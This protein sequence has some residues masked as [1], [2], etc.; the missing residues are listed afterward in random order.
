MRMT[1]LQEWLVLLVVTLP[2]SAVSAGTLD[3]TVMLGGVIMNQDGDRTAVQETYNV[4][5]GFSVSQ[6]SLNGAPTG[7]DHFTLD[8]RE[9]NLDSRKADFVYRR[10]GIFKLTA[11]YD[12]DRQVFAP[13]GGVNSR[14]KDL[15]FGA[16]YA[17]V[18]W[19]ALS[20]NFD[21]L[22][23]DGDRLSY[24]A[25][26]MGVLGSQ[27]DN[28]L[29]TGQLT[30]E[31]HRGRVGGALSYSVSDFSDQ[32]DGAADRTG[33]VL[34]ARFYAPC[35]FYNKWTHLVRG[36][37]GV[38]KLSDNDIEYKLSSFEYTGVVA[39]VPAF[40]FRY[41][42]D[43]SR[44]DDQATAL[45]TDRFQN[46]FDA[47]YLYKFGQ[48]SGGYGYETN[49]DDDVLTHYHS[50]RGGTVFRYGK[51]VTARVSYAGRNK[52]DEEDLTLLKDI[53][54]NQFR[55]Q[56]QAQPIGPLVVGGGYAQRER[57]YPDIHVKSDGDAANGFARYTYAGWGSVSAD[58]SYATDTYHDLI[59][60]FDTRSDIVTGRVEFD[61]IR[62]LRLAGGVT[63]LD[64]GRDLDIEKSMV[65]AEGAYTLL[66]NYRIEV[67]YNVYNYDDYILVDRY[68]TANVLRI[69]LGYDF[70]LK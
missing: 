58:F 46:Y 33:Q 36:A 51:L 61:R 44:V 27:Y 8:L 5:D 30:A 17:P 18:K 9:I 4:F 60:G 20:G 25:G 67:K 19:L 6:L 38:R 65:F 32:V 21:N 64:I 68:Y 41:N 54:S 45:K 52:K 47:T 56:L 34:S 31:A 7:T 63:Y 37:Y 50:W 53:E 49:D 23:R 43:A 2:V 35:R 42:F 28:A 11:G 29:R 62:N 66:N 1:T 3:G 13:D 70:N 59:A 26:T 14:R 12:Q 15:R 39:P 69:N 10:P 40:E 22:S 48:V 16:Q 55:A 57:E 24:P